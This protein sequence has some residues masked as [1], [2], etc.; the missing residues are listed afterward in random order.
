VHR[1]DLTATID[2]SRDLNLF[3]DHSTCGSTGLTALSL[4]SL[5]IVSRRCENSM[6]EAGS[7]YL[8]P[9]SDRSQFSSPSAIFHF[10]D[11]GESSQCD[12]NAV[13][14]VLLVIQRRY[15]LPMGPTTLGAERGRRTAADPWGAGPTSRDANPERFSRWFFHL[16]SFGDDLACGALLDHQN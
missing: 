8:R 6:T 4:D 13:F 10:A 11:P 14:R 7:D 9:P 12:S 5:T 15:G 16:G 3:V 2:A 1:A